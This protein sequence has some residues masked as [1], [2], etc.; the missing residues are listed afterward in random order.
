MAVQRFDILVFG[1]GHAGTAFAIH[2][3]NG[4]AR[5][6]VVDRRRRLPRIGEIVEA[7]LQ[8]PLVRLGVWGTF[9]RDD[10]LRATGT[11][12]AWGDAVPTFRSAVINPFG[13]GWFVDRERFDAMF[14]SE[15]IA[16]GV[17]FFET[18]ARPTAGAAGYE[19]MA[20]GD[21]VLVAPLAIEATGR[22]GFAVGPSARTLQDDL[23]AVMAYAP[24]GSDQQFRLEAVDEGWWYSAPLPGARQVLTLMTSMR[25]LPRDRSERMSF[26]RRSLEH[27]D[28]IVGPP[29]ATQLVL[30][31]F[32]AT[33]GLRR[34]LY[35][36]RWLAIGDAAAAYDPLHGFGIVAALTK[37]I[38]AATLLTLPGSPRSAF[39]LYAETEHT[40]FGKYDRTRRHLYAQAASGWGK[41]A[42]WREY[43]TLGA[44]RTH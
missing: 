26:W 27:C 6:A 33:G 2:A 8:A 39:D 23:V 28:L 34:V 18:D 43:S 37:G 12:S 13:G 17:V 32:P 16:R 4:G 35:G 9:L 19:V 15:A 42:F 7:A 25:L 20:P 31:V 44:V 36:D 10:H 38:A 1:A 22:H 41:S 24:G 5:V 3:A 14:V 40:A 30:A 11:L 21:G 29:R